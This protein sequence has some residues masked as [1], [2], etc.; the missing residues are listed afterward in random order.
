M[1][2][3]ALAFGGTAGLKD[4]PQ[5]VHLAAPHGVT[6]DELGITVQRFGVGMQSVDGILVALAE[7]G[8]FG[9]RL[10]TDVREVDQATAYRQIRRR[11][12]RGHRLGG[13]HRINEYEV[14]TGLLLG[15][16]QHGL[17]ILVIAHAPG[18]GGANRVQLGHPA[19]QTAALHRVKQIDAIRCTDQSGVLHTVGD[20]DVQRMVTNRQIGGND[21]SRI[22]NERTIQVVGLGSISRTNFN[23]ALI[24]LAILQ[25]DARRRHVQNTGVHQHP[26]LATG[27]MQH[28]GCH[29][30]GVT[31]VQNASDGDELGALAGGV[32]AQRCQHLD[33]DVIVYLVVVMAHAQITRADTDQLGQ[34]N[35]RTG[36][37]LFT[38][39]NLTHSPSLTPFDCATP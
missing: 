14:G 18:V 34:S 1:V 24:W 6:V 31:L 36:Q 4:N 27:D 32:D 23:G 3:Y 22:R 19:P 13:M 28:G 33:Q 5:G 17:Q 21:H 39:G 35:Q 10:R 15:V 25:R 12:E 2:E 37:T 29:Q 20:L 9:D 16:H 7:R 11:G 30:S 26:V 8:I 38:L